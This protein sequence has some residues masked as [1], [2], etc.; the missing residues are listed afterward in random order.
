MSRQ[1]VVLT[2]RVAVITGSTRGIG[3]SIAEVF[4]RAGASVVVSS[5]QA[6]AV[7][8]TVA[9]L[10]QQ[11]IRCSGFVCDVSNRAEVITLVQ[12]ALD[13]YGHIDI[14]VNN[15]GISGPFGYTLDVPPADWEQVLRVNVLGCYYGCTAVLPHM[16]ARRYGKIVNLS[17][18][19]AY[20]A[21]RFLSAYSASKAAI[22][23]FSEGLVREYNQAFLSINVLEPGLVETDMITRARAVGAASVAL[24]HMPFLLQTMGTTTEETAELALHMVS[25]AT[26]GVSGKVFRVM[27]RY[28]AIWRMLRAMLDRQTQKKESRV[29]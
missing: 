13:S 11:N 28:R 16:L 5:S 26:D 12:Q 15:A 19:G 21:Q 18:G 4:G 7:A 25:S 14:W 2:N 23:R 9:D 29:T 24:K 1:A 10:T 6:G 27:P 17:G 3:R 8:R 20:R 22:V